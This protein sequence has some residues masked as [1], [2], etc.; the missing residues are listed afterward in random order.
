MAPSSWQKQDFY[1]RNVG[2]GITLGIALFLAFLTSLLG[3]G[4]LSVPIVGV[5]V[6]VGMTASVIIGSRYARAMVRILKFDCEE[7]ERDFRL[8]FKDNFI[9]FHRRD[10]E[11]GY[12]YDLLGHGLTMTVEPYQIVS[13]GAEGRPTWFVP[14]TRVTLSGLTTQN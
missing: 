14:A 10:E 1:I 12:R 9:Q 7:I 5:V 3:L 6:L 11:E 2:I 8:L 13:G 4:R